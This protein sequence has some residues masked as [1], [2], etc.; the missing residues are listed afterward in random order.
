M[1]KASLRKAMIKAMTKAKTVSGLQ[2]SLQLQLKK[3]STG[4]QEY[5]IDIEEE[6]DYIDN[7]L[8]AITEAHPLPRIRAYADKLS[9]DIIQKNNGARTHSLSKYLELCK[10]KEIK[11]QESSESSPQTDVVEALQAETMQDEA[12]N[13]GVSEAPA[14]SAPHWQAQRHFHLVMRHPDLRSPAPRRDTIGPFPR[15][16]S[17][18]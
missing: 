4:L 12:T 15:T 1:E 3:I 9:D 18:P 10:S 11:L 17:S 14:R 7:V 13:T 8:D 2:P 5:D 6:G 16:T